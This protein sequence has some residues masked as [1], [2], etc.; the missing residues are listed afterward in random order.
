MGFIHQVTRRPT[1]RST[2]DCEW[3][4]RWWRREP[5]ICETFLKTPDCTRAGGL[6]TISGLS[7]GQH[8]TAMMVGD[9]NK[10]E[11]AITTAC[12]PFRID[13]VWKIVFHVV[14]LRG[15]LWI[16]FPIPADALFR[17]DGRPVCVA[18]CGWWCFPSIRKSVDKQRDSGPGYRW[19]RAIRPNRYRLSPKLVK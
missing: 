5:I 11:P 12:C 16:S 3:H 14:K 4:W 10:V 1:D 7:F 13:F 6:E 18:P 2:G 9:K 19:C 17:K 15:F 8:A